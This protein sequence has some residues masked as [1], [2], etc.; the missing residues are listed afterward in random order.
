MGAYSRHLVRESQPPQQTALFDIVPVHCHPDK[1]NP[2]NLKLETIH[3]WRMPD[4]QSQSDLYFVIDNTLPLLL[5]VGE[6][7]YLLVDS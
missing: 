6:T 7:K 1:I 4:W 5:Y 3:F 2:F